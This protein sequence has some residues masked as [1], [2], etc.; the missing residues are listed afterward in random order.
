M[1]KVWKSIILLIAVF[2]ALTLCAC[3]T[4]G[5]K[6]KDYAGCY[7][8]TYTTST[9]MTTYQEA[10]VI[11]KQGNVRYGMT[12]SEFTQT[13]FEGTLNIENDKGVFYCS[14]SYGYKKEWINEFP[15][16]LTLLN[17]GDGLNAI[18]TG[19][20][21]SRNFTKVSEDEMNA[22]CEENYIFL[23]IE[24]LK[25]PIDQRTLP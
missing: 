18:F 24:E 14:D 7:I 19:D 11:D 21:G 17:D 25:K 10:M 23:D 15:L 12:T 22:F 3:G 9:G 5:S 2:S 1:N 20:L 13:A 6:V 16:T 4:K 8:T